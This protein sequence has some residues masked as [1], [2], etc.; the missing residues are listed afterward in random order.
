[1]ENNN[2]CWIQILDESQISRWEL[3]LEICD[4]LPNKPIVSCK[5]LFKCKYNSNGTIAHLKSRLVAR[6]CIQH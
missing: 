4:A 3:N 6:R 1:M 5:W 2:G